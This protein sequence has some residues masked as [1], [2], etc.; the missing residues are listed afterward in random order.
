[1][2]RIAFHKSGGHRPRFLQLPA[3]GPFSPGG[4]RPRL[5][6]TPTRPEAPPTKRS[7]TRSA[8]AFP[9]QEGSMCVPRRQKLPLGVLTAQILEEPTI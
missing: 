3:P 2:W 6:A 7:L 1:M 5:T 9:D 8:F 4:A